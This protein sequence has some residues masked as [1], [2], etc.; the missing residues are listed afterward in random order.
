MFSVDEGLRGG[1][2]EAPSVVASG[3]NFGAIAATTI[4]HKITKY[5]SSLKLK[6]I[7][8]LKAF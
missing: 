2:I 1:F 4:S 3:V 8:F 5:F 6:L 7:N